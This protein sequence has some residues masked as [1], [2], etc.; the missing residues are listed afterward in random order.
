MTR[1]EAATRRDFGLLLAL[2]AWI[3]GTTWIRPLL[4]P[5]EG[6]Y[7]GV[8]WEM[9]QH[10]NW[11]TPTL[12]GLPFFHK[13]PLFYWITE[14]ALAA[15][16]PAEWASRA[17][18]VLGAW[19]GATALYLL[20][21]RWCGRCL[22]RSLLAAL[23]AQPLFVL[24]GQY[25]NLDML[26]AGCITATIA[27]LA[28][29]VLTDEAGLLPRWSLPGAYAMAGLG[30]LAKGLIGFVLP[31]LVIL[32]WLAA[33]RRTRLVPRLVSVPGLMLFAA[34]VVPWFVAMQLRHERFLDYFFV[35]QHVKR[36]AA[37]GFN[38]VQPPWFYVV[39]LLVFFAL[40][41]PWIRQLVRSK[42]AAGDGQRLRALMAVWS[43]VIVIFFSIPQSKLV[44]YV[45]PAVP[46]LAWLAA[47]GFRASG[48]WPHAWRLVAGVGALVSLATVAYLLAS[49]LHSNKAL[50]LALQDHRRPGEPVVML[51]GYYY[52]VPFYAGLVDPVPVVDD[53]SSPDVDRRD[54]WRKELADAGR[55]DPGLGARLL[56]SPGRLPS[57][58]CVSPI[59]WVIGP[60]GAASRH[61]ILNEAALMFAK[62][63]LWLWRFERA[64]ATT[65]CA[66]MPMNDR[67]GT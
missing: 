59:T 1:P 62:D 5:D 41:L 18:P 48:R 32:A 63:G 50:A 13:P 9:L 12:D 31:A 58:L 11:L 44:G 30:V 2:C 54:N 47:D 6:R 38:N 16:G 19:L 46:P 26:V 36:F 37:G 66:Q 64:K 35:V 24:G 14:V 61:P 3:A 40:W 45:L 29:A 56:V 51:E 17:A 4:L 43:A 22:A 55:F 27:L 8:A 57:L 34:I 53:W 21:L 23:A 60:A 39:I 28:D 10:G 65:G 15:A 49:S 67:A 52:D 7:V 33:T 42:P 25:A 20:T